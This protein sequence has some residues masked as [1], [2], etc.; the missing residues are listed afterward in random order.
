[1]TKRL[2]TITIIAAVMLAIG[3]PAKAN[4]TYSFVCIPPYTNPLNVP[5]GEAQLFVDVSDPG[6]NQVLFTF[7][8]IGPHPSSIT[9]VYFDDGGLLG[10]A[11][12]NNGPGVMFSQGATPPEL[13]RGNNLIPK[14][15]TTDNFSA[16]SDQ[17]HLMTNGV[18]PGEW[19]GITFDLQTGKDFDDI[20]DN[21][22][23][24]D[25][26]IG[27]H[28]QAFET[29]VSE[30]FVNNGISIIPAPGAI[31]L[32]SIGVGLVGWLRRRRAL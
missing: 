12:I 28:V 8:N 22:A 4:F 23:S 17:P 2:F 25:L 18:N 19:L 11:S 15:E 20:I 14:F 10:I 32:G 7:T 1:M 30:A 26:R 27:I 24:G 29:G 31:L 3:I 13:P 9:D 5:I 6:G 21:L 16:D